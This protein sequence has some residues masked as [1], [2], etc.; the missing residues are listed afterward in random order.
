MTK[1]RLAFCL[2]GILAMN[3]ISWATQWTVSNSA[4]APALFM[5]PTALQDAIDS[6]AVGD[7]LLVSGTGI[8]Y[9]DVVIDKALTLIG[10][11]Y[12][13][14]AQ[15]TMVD[16]LDIRSSNVFVTGFSA[17][18]RIKL[19]AFNALSQ[20]LANV[21]VARCM[22]PI[23][24]RGSNTVGSGL[25]SDV[26]VRESVIT[27]GFANGFTENRF[28]FDTLSFINNIFRSGFFVN[29]NG[30]QS[31]QFIGTET[32][33]LDHN[34]FLSN[35]TGWGAFWS[36]YIATPAWP[37]G[38]MIVSNNIFRGTGPR[39]CDG[40]C[41]INNMTYGAGPE[42]NDTALVM[43]CDTVNFWNVDPGI[44]GGLFNMGNDY[45]LPL[46]SPAIGA[47]SDS[48]DI[49]IT[50]GL[51]P[52]VVGAPPPGP[53]VEFVNVDE[54]AVPPDSL[55]HY[56]VLA[57]A[58]ET[59]GVQ[60][61][62]LEYLFDVDGG[63]GTGTTVAFPPATDWDLITEAYALGL[64]SGAHTFGVRVRDQSGA[65][66]ASKWTALDVCNTYGPDAAFE[67][68][69]T[70]RTVSF[71]DQ[72]R[73]ATSLV[74]E[75]G[76][77]VSDTGDNPSHTYAVAGAY[78][79]LQ[80]ATSACGVDT[81][82]LIASISG[83]SGYWPGSSSNTGFC[84]ITLNGAGFSPN[85]E[86]R[87]IDG[88]LNEIIPDSIYTVSNTQAFAM[89][90][91]VGA[92]TGSYAIELD[93]PGDT[94]VHIEN[95]FTIGAQADSGVVSVVHGPVVMRQN[96]WMP[97]DIEVSNT[98]SVD[99]YAVPVFV[100]NTEGVQVEWDIV[101]Y[102]PDTLGMDSIPTTL[103]VDTIGGRP[104]QGELGAWVI[105]WIPANSSIHIRGRMRTQLVTGS[106]EILCWNARP[107]YGN[108]LGAFQG[109][110]VP[111]GDIFMEFKDCLD[112]LLDSPFDLIPG[113]T[114]VKS[115]YDAVVPPYVAAYKGKPLEVVEILEFFPP[116]G[117]AIINCS[118]A[119]AVPG[120]NA[121]VA[122][123]LRGVVKGHDLVEQA[124]CIYNG[125]QFPTTRRYVVGFVN[126]VDPNA[127][128]GDQ[129]YTIEQYV[130]DDRTFTY[131][132]AFENLD[133][134]AVPAQR[135]VISDTLDAS[136]LDLGRAFLGDIG[137]KDTVYVTDPGVRS[138][139]KI[140]PWDSGYELRLNATIDTVNAVAYWDIF[141]VD[142]V[143][144]ALPLDP[145]VGFLPPNVTSPEGQGFVTLHIPMKDGLMHGQVI[146]NLATI[147]FDQN[148]PITTETWLNTLDLVP[149][150]SQVDPLPST[151]TDTL[152][153]VS[154]IGGADDGS[155]IARYYVYASADTTIGYD[156]W[157]VTGA[158]SGVFDGENGTTYHFYVVA[159]DS[160]GNMEVKSPVSEAQTYVDF[161][162]AVEAITSE[163]V[164]DLFPNPTTG[165]ITLVGSTDAPCILQVEVRNMVGQVHE[166]RSFATGSGLIRVSLD[167]PKLAVGTYIATIKCEDV[168]LV[169]RLIKISE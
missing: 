78:P 51:F 92:P 2:F 153:S 49:G 129:G 81:A 148:T 83:I 143:E 40:C 150:T 120:V 106:G 76:D 77:G 59:P 151:T 91:L 128:Y 35:G 45:S 162:T 37:A 48:T 73:Y 47:A 88:S 33:I 105:P 95:G 11:G 22:G 156:L 58:F 166:Q 142:V 79:V 24:L 80:I 54:V 52:L 167:L 74:Y 14:V 53:K 165:G 5:G 97:V 155:G 154:W 94:L 7:T 63:I 62:S 101:T 108:E 44:P 96:V 127:K 93:L 21:V 41:F 160:V 164:F 149:P 28:V 115:V 56:E 103:P 140:I 84:T 124:E 163:G 13:P 60:L 137:V 43:A 89:L 27:I 10:A 67:Q 42:D 99:V 158:T 1:V 107:M 20:E 15:A 6:A 161:N 50:G 9:G 29:P 119:G 130:A 19:N 75:F 138:L 122:K 8:T 123:I 102:V 110:N 69:R 121:V 146:E 116:L 86:F 157:L 18:T 85:M 4:Q 26:I 114:C 66:S 152:V 144:H 71:V 68:Y 70:G 25:I 134:A 109:G 82:V 135:V 118:P 34:D 64:D 3:A 36:Q 125:C 139:A 141:M 104:F 72:S 159:E 38:E 55:F 136:T 132:I 31:S 131:T 39:G 32:I 98:G 61:D 46:G 30:S 57:H 169:E 126:S 90:N 111:L 168:K 23:D 65:W 145:M 87:L 17:D 112:C 133:T 100:A 16:E 147:L 117:S 12:S 113:Y